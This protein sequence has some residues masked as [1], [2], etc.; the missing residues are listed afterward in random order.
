M[1]KLIIC[2][3]LIL[4]EYSSLFAQNVFFDWAKP[5][6]TS[7]DEIA[8]SNTV[9]KYGNSYITG[10]FY[11]KLDFNPGTDTFFLSSN[12]ENDIFILKLD[13]KGD[14]VWAKSIGGKGDDK[15]NSIVS[16][17]FG[18]FYITGTFNSNVD[19]DPDTSSKIL[20][21]KGGNDAFIAKFNS[22]GKIYWVNTLV[23]NYDES[24]NGVTLNINGNVFWTGSFQDTLFFTIGTSSKSILISKGKNDIFIARCDT[25]GSYIWVKSM[26]G[27]GDDVSYSIISD[28]NDNVI[29][30][31]YFTDKCNFGTG[32][33]SYFLTSFGS[34]DA[35]ISKND[36]K[37]NYIFAYQFG[38]TNEEIGKSVKLDAYGNIYSTGWFNGT[39]DFNPSKA[40]AYLY[41]NG[42]SDI[43]I[44]RLSSGG[45]FSWVKQIGG[46]ENDKGNS[47]QIDDNFNIYS[48]GFYEARVDFDPGN[49]S[50][51]QTS[52]G[53]EDVYVS[54]LSS[55]GNFVWAKSFGGRNTDIGNTICLSFDKAVFTAGNFSDTAD[56]NPDKDSSNIIAIGNADAFIQKMEICTTSTG[57]I[58][59]SNCYSITINGETFTSSGTYYQKLTT[60]RGCDSLLILDITIFTTTIANLD[61]VACKSYT[62]N[63]TTYTQPGTYYQT[64]KNSKGC[65]SIIVLNL[66]FGESSGSLTAIACDKYTFYGTTYNNSGTYKQIIKNHLGCDSTI[67]LKLTIKKSTSSNIKVTACNSFSIK[68]TTYTKSG[69][70]TQIIKNYNDCD[71]VINLD[72]T[73]NKS[74]DTTILAEACNTFKLNS[75]TYNQSGTYKQ[76]LK[77][78]ANC[79]S[80][81]T[82]ILKIKNS[83]SI[84][85][86]VA[87]K[88]FTIGKNTFTENGTYNVTIP[89]SQGCDSSV[90]LNLTIKNIDNTVNID[91]R[92]LSSNQAD[93]KYQW[94]DC[95]KNFTPIAGEVYKDILIKNT[96]KYA[97]KVTKDICVDTSECILLDFDAVRK[98]N[99]ELIKIIPNPVFDELNIEISGNWESGS[100]KI[101]NSI[102]KNI[103]QL[104][105]ISLK[106][107]KLDV[108]DFP[109]GIYFIEINSNNAT[110]RS[111]FIKI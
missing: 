87:C 68:T 65:D 14:F 106:N 46:T 4:V 56:F 34:S 41:S 9:D 77:N 100:L 39:A 86:I 18:N 47:L 69:T 17:S 28:K 32:T 110:I 51:F 70:Y 5:L 20:N 53:K 35:F 24:G 44:S 108:S 97:V 3:L 6:G 73:I 7:K 11:G 105:N 38:G 2:L 49:S 30:T 54:K 63:G 71:S 29:I 52:K 107:F 60:K 83:S 89:N 72:L 33:T 31:G 21:A 76:V 37:G 58:S 92:I 109:K 103:Y 74:T 12:G 16:D 84:L 42:K 93:A 36:A 104:K 90:I 78:K 26:G 67:T 62:L 64:I 61:V 48:T 40:T 85:D 94:L 50:Y 88:S 66:S 99:S 45:A 82:L 1:K 13:K 95:N 55:T 59:A 15:C 80:T 79:D 96:G 75:I 101:Y 22:Y 43:Y 91:G 111:H 23:G 81:I 98:I 8:Y 25:G 27:N 57:N 102:S 19:F 10:T